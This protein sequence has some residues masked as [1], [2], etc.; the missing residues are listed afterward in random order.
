MVT[1]WWSREGNV[2]LQIFLAT[3]GEFLDLNS[4]GFARFHLDR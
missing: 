3:V 2:A 4:F 1:T